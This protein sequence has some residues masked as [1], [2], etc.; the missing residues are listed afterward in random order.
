MKHL[1]SKSYKRDFRIHFDARH[2][3]LLLVSLFCACPLLADDFTQDGIVYSLDDAT[4]TATVKGLADKTSTSVTIPNS[5]N[6]YE[7]TTI[8]EKAFLSCEKLTSVDL[9][10]SITKIGNRAFMDCTALT[11]IDLPNSLTSIGESAFYYTG[12]TSINIP[13]SVT[14]IGVSAFF[15]CEALASVQLSN[16]I[17]KIENQT[18]AHCRALTS[19]DI[20]NSVKVIDYSAF[21]NCEKLQ[22]ATIPNSVTSIG[23]SVFCQTALTAVHLPNS[24]ESIGSFCFDRCSALTSVIIPNSVK[25][26]GSYAFRN[27]ENL[28]TI[29]IQPT[30]GNHLYLGENCFLGVNE[31]NPSIFVLDKCAIDLHEYYTSGSINDFLGS[32]TW[33]VK[34]VPEFYDYEKNSVDAEANFTYNLLDAN[35]LANLSTIVETT[36]ATRKMMQNYAAE[37]AEQPEALRTELEGYLNRVDKLTMEDV[38]RDNYIAELSA[39]LKQAYTTI[40]SKVYETADKLQNLYTEAEKLITTDYSSLTSTGFAANEG[41]I[42][43]VSQLKSEDLSSLDLLIDNNSITTYSGYNYLQMDLR[44]PYKQLLLKLGLYNMMGYLCKLDGAPTTL[45]V[46]ATNTPDDENSWADFGTKKCNYKKAA[47]T[48]QLNFNSK[49]YRYVRLV[50]EEVYNTNNGTISSG[51]DINFELAELRAYTRAC[52]ADV[53]SEST[54]TALI[55]A[56][57]QAKAELDADKVTKATLNTLQSA[58]DAANNEIGT[59]PVLVDFTKT[60]YLTLYHNQA[61]KVPTGVTAAVVVEQGDGIRNDYRYH[62][63]STIPTETG[64]LIKGHKGNSYYFASTQ[65]TETAPIDNL[66]HGTL[67]DEQTYVEGAGKYYKLSFD[68]ATG[69]NLGFYWGAEGGA[70]FVNKG[71]KAFLALPTAL[72]ANHVAGFTMFD[73]DNDHT[74][75]SIQSAPAADAVSHAKVYDLN[76]HRINATNTNELPRGIYIINGKKVIK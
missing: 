25:S 2:W 17:T 46:Y 65:S 15:Q 19:I 21:Y 55:A 9:P 28:K 48:V 44:A 36:L 10:N 52:K 50:V 41:L 64:V 16:Q 7:V 23:N 27:C 14:S 62:S 54:H 70:A 53:L 38:D 12:L 63:A 35:T 51:D 26:V 73:L 18:F 56:M 3:L 74:L 33:Y 61:L 11:S 4:K 24:L 1:I 8:G 40:S 75:T 29:F 59:D 60:D 13:N 39:N 30:Q 43:E 42:T 72:Y 45:H 49:A 68:N 5:V 32:N 47:A 67:S 34:S 6:G 22:S 66:L 57:A 20:P 76:G 37:Y 71:G 58:Y 69:Q 31:G